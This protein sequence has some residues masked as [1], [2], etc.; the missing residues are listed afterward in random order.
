MKQRQPRSPVGKE[1][2]GPNPP[3]KGPVD[4]LYT[5][6][7]PDTK[8]KPIVFLGAGASV[9]SGIPTSDQ[10]VEK[11]AKWAYCETLGLHLDDPGVVR[12]DWLRWLHGHSWYRQDAPTSDNYSAV[13]EHLLQPRQ[14]RKDFFLRV[15]KPGVPASVGYHQLLKLLDDGFIDTILTTNF[16]NVFLEVHAANNRPHHIDVIRTPADCT[17]LSTAPTYP[18]Y[19]FLHGTV[20]HY[21][22]QN[23]VAEV[24]QLDSIVVERLTPLLRDRPLIVVGY[25][26]AEPSIMKHLFL[27]SVG[28]TE[29]FRQGLFWC[30]RQTDT[31]KPH[32][33]VEELRSTIG[34]NFQLIGIDGFDELLGQ[35]AERCGTQRSSSTLARAISN[36]HSKE[37][38]PFDMSI[39]EAPLEEIDWVR[40]QT[41][42]LTYCN[43]MSIQ[44]PQQIERD[45]L[46][47]KMSELD[48]ASKNGPRTVLTAAGYL[49]FAKSPDARIKGASTVVRI[50]GKTESQ[51]TGNLWSQ[52]DALIDLADQVNRPFRLK[53]PVS[54]EAF[55]Y[56]KLALKELLVN[57]LVH[58]SYE[59]PESL[60]LDIE[61]SFLRITNPGGL[62]EAVFA[63]VD[64]NLQQHIEQGARGI[65]GYRN[66]VL[67]D[68][69]YGAGAMDKE[70]SGLPDVQTEVRRNGGQ[71]TY[72]PTHG[73]QSFRAVIY[74]RLESV[75]ERTRTA[76]VL[77]QRTKYSANLLE[78]VAHPEILW[79]GV[80]TA[81]KVGD[82]VD[83]LP[84]PYGWP[85]VWKGGEITTFS[86]LTD[87]QNP[88]T[89]FVKK[90]SVRPHRWSGWEA[91]DDR[92]REL[93]WL[94]NE[95]FYK[96]LYRRLMVV[97]RYRKRAYF[98]RTDKGSR[99]I[100]YRASFRQATR[101][102]TKAVI[103]KR[104]QHVVY[105]EH[106]AFWFGFEA[107]A[108]TWALRI[109][110]GYVFTTDGDRTLLHHKRVGALATKKAARDYNQQVFNDLVFWAWIFTEGK[111]TASLS[112]GGPS[113][114]ELMGSLSSCELAMPVGTDEDLS[115]EY[116]EQTDEELEEIEREIADEAEANLQ[117]A[118][119]NADGD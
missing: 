3:V 62:V 79:T 63:R 36:N 83:Q 101:T 107:F 113:D 54:E 95:C 64:G 19:V 15:T 33:L 71:V 35:L 42:L 50:D 14:A 24:Q 80:S 56:P 37:G 5:L 8:P 110:P 82:I 105:W 86:D 7:R 60:V 41:V 49:L 16:D 28:A 69:F 85:F 53:G 26:G 106:E 76:P 89:R 31:D 57:A 47:E 97:D 66:P 38:L 118:K 90:S 117:E 21:T 94:V 88:L 114:I 10:L 81:K 108:N 115:Y 9:R 43:A 67:A 55:P 23:L 77:G 18:Q 87:P 12:S 99:E 45:W 34:T 73:N 102:V 58:R 92:C 65:K 46:L 48:L 22:D 75:D 91:D 2:R 72:G 96:M 84:S 59:Q 104:T 44:M 109:L 39:I 100:T 93:V 61:D 112:T 11:A 74:R 29:R 17:M 52:L 119:P 20:E 70:G 116:T 103:S 68:L 30:S 6:F 27:N 13:V 111:E 51:F 1:E 40:V 4:R 32:P 98:P 78:V 25:R